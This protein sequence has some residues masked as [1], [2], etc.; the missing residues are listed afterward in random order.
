MKYY[1]FFLLSFLLNNLAY[2]KDTLFTE[3]SNDQISINAGFTG[4]RLV[5]YGAID[6]PGDVAVAVTGPRTTFRVRFKE[7]I[8]GIW[9]NKKQIVFKDVPGYYAVA[10]TRKL[11]DLN[12]ERALY[13]SQIGVNNLRFAGA[14]EI[15]DEERN[16]WKS[17]LIKTMFETNRYVEKVGKI[18]LSDD[19]LFKTEVIFPSVIPSGVYTVDT[20]LLKKGNVIGAKRTLIKVA[21]SGLGAKVY[22]L[23]HSVGLLYGFFAVFLA[24][25]I[26]WIANETIRRT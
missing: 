11:E 8:W 15:M 17:G 14:E 5:L 6:G 19:T 12:A 25:F 9:I 24:L 20:L 1:V 23:A 18:E 4:A 26:G 22:D 21:K 7:K 3:L 13:A 10:A 16:K 2:T